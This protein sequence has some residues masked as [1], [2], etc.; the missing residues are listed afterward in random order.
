MVLMGGKSQEREI[1]LKTGDAIL[2]ALREL[3]HEA[4]PLDLD[5]NLCQK[6]LELKPDKVFIALHGTYGEDGRVQGLLDILGIPYTGSGV[7]GSCLAM[8]KEI[9]KKILAFHGIPVPKGVCVRRGESINW[10]K[11]PAIVKPADQ[12]SSV[13]LHLVKGREELEMAVRKVLDI[14]QK[15]LIEEYIEGRDITVGILKDQVLPPLEV[16]PKRNIYDYESKYTKGMSDYVFL[17][18]D[19]LIKKLQDIALKVHKYL[20]LKDISRIDF[21]VSKDGTPYVLEANTIPGMTELS[22]FPMM[23]MK[24]GIDF[25]SMVQMLIS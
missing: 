10:D 15:A 8:D 1:S 21:R 17:E 20:E 11:F 18:D 25:K 16:R 19:D 2:K 23:C 14:S 24:M 12:G 13:G 9:T 3:G 7:L 6:L 5:E 4:I 22:L